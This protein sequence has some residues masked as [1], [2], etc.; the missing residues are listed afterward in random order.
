MRRFFHGLLSAA[1]LIVSLGTA[2]AAT[3]PGALDWSYAV[4]SPVYSSPVVG[5]D[6][7]I[8]VGGGDIT[9][10]WYT[11]TGGN[12]LYAFNPD[13]SLKWSYAAGDIIWS[14]P[15][16][17]ADGTIYFGSADSNLYAV[18]DGGTEG[19]L[20]WTYATGESINYSS[21]AVAP[22]GSIYVGSYDGNLYAVKDAGAEATLKWSYA[23]GDRIASSP[24]IGADGTVYVGSLD[25]NLYAITDG[26]TKA[27][28]KW[29]YATGDSIYSSPAVGVDGTVYVGSCDA[30]LYAVNPKGTRKW[31]F[32]TG[33]SVVSS[34]AIGADGT[35][36]VGSGDGKLYALNPTGTKK[37]SFATGDWITSSPAVGAD[38]TIYVGSSDMNL[39]AVNPAGT[40]KW[41]Y[42]TGDA[43]YSSPAIGPDGTVYVGSYDSSLYA[44]YG[45]LPGSA[46]APWPMFHN[47]PRRTG[48]APPPLLTVTESGSGTVT[49]SPSGIDCG[50]DCTSGYALN[51]KVTLTPAPESGFIFAN[52]SGACT[53]TGSC[54]VTMSAAKSVEAV[55][56]A[57]SCIYS[58]S[59]KSKA[60][61]YK[62]GTV[63]VGVTAKGSTSCTAPSITE[64]AGWIGVQSSTFSMTKGTVTLTIPEYD[65]ASRS[66]T[67]TIG[68]QVF[69]VTE[70]G[71]H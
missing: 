58:L 68:G 13:G 44:V 60:F 20:K 25:N 17:G 36:Y 64:Q 32:T 31:T 69:T 51:T 29:S 55:F 61:T 37:W 15:A 35:I 26:G 30:R 42:A 23:T 9:N 52:W 10:M 65:T 24:A 66:G 48:A 11:P 49:S 8:Y 43:I 28:L 41:S 63:T 4:S 39:Y 19:I 57:G 47:G 33:N 62:G 27:V 46:T 70:A 22:G 53:G 3:Q 5:A 2:R 54:A 40:K 6:G 1:F 14:S 7:T 59:S 50:Q 34:P 56:E 16:I 71:K 67:V 18:T 38:G 45:S 21:P 12:V